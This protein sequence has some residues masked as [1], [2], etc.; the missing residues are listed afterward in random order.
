[1]ISAATG[2]MAVGMVKLVKDHGP[3]FLVPAIPVRRHP[4]DGRT[5]DA[6]CLGANG[7]HHALRPEPSPQDVPMPLGSCS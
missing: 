5:A 1:M 4:P 6:H 3:R 2:A 7:F